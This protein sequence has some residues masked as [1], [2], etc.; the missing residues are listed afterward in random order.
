MPQDSRR[1]SRWR[2]RSTAGLCDVQQHRA[3]TGH[4]VIDFDVHA[5]TADV[6]DGTE[7]KLG[8]TKDPVALQHGVPVSHASFDHR[9]SMEADHSHLLCVGMRIE[10]NRYA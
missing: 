7:V 8:G 10:K 1:C 4:V 9:L 5:E 6:W 3:A 2:R